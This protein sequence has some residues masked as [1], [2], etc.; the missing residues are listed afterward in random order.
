V[1]PE[2]WTIPGIGFHIRSYGATIAVGILLALWIGMRRAR[3]VGADP[4]TITS[5]CLVGVLFGIL[6]CR[7]MHFVHH[8]G[9]ALRSGDIGVREV[10]TATSGGEIVGGIILAVLGAIVYLAVRRKSIGLYLDIAF[11]PMILAMGVGRVGCFLFG[12]CWGGVCE[13][14]GG[15]RALPWAVQFPYGSPPHERAWADGRSDVPEAL[16][17]QP[18]KADSATPIPREVLQEYEIDGNEA[19]QTWVLTAEKAAAAH[20]ADPESAEAKSL[21]EELTRSTRALGRKARPEE[22]FAVLHLRALRL[23]GTPMSWTELRAL[24]AQQHSHWVH[25]AQLYD[26]IA[27]TLIFVVLSAIFWRRRQPGMVVA[28]GM[29]LYGVNRVLQEMIRGDNPHDTFGLT[30]SQFMSL[31]IVAGG[32]VIAV[33]LTRR[34]SSAILEGRLRTLNS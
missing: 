2:I 7:V 12:C 20:K 26:A 32:I 24:A 29:I 23:G 27:C 34:R 11:P 33:V 25:P 14:P 21:A 17:W 18:P 4:S 19:L 15:A 13:T 1:H 8:S 9:D 31:A 30:I 3:R 10:V 22:V 28:W 6:G 16:M 5:L